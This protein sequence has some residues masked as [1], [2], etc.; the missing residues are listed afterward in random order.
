MSQLPGWAQ[1]LL[2]I[3]VLLIVVAILIARLPK[4]ELGHSPSFLKRR[5]G[6]WFPVGLT[7]AFLY[8]GRY[9][10]NVCKNALGDV[11]SKGD[12]GT[13]FFWGTLTYGCSFVINGP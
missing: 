10:L 3:L 5:F 2:P 7:Y 9:N 13:I 11:M 12:F 8:M 6:N 4:I 1:E